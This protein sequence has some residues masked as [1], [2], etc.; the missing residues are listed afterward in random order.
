MWGRG[1]G[2]YGG[3]QSPCGAPSPQARMSH[4]AHLWHFLGIYPQDMA[5]ILICLSPCPDFLS[6]AVRII[7]VVGGHWD[8]PYA[9]TDV[10]LLLIY[11]NGHF[12]WFNLLRAEGRGHL[13]PILQT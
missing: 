2:G 7:P 8:K 12:I 3:V 1:V 4:T 13:S 5:S 11:R 6:G 9:I 10:Q